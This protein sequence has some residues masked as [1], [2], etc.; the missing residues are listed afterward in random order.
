MNLKSRLF[1]KS[2]QNKDPEIRAQAVNESDDPE[3]KS[4]LTR[5][6]Q[7]DESALVRLAALNRI[8]T[9]HFW[10]DARLRETDDAIIAAADAFLAREVPRKA[11]PGLEAERLQWFAKTASSDLTRRMA[12]QAA[13]INLRRAALER[14]NSQGFLGDCFG[15]ETDEVLANEILERID[16]ESTL[17]RLAESLRKTSKKRAQAAADR[18]SLLRQASGKSG[19]D[20]RNANQLVQ[21]AEALARGQGDSDRKAALEELIRQWS[22]VVQPTEALERRFE[23]AVSIVRASLDRPARGVAPDQPEP[24]VATPAASLKLQEAATH[25]RN[26][27]RQARKEIKPGELL[28]DWDRAWNQLSQASEADL[29]LKEDMLPL[30]RELQV[31]A[32]QKAGKKPK[33]EQ[34]TPE[35]DPAK[36]ENIAAELDVRLDTIAQ[37]LE[38]GDIGKSHDLIRALRTDF[39]RL[40]ARARPRAVGGRL[41]RM[42]GRLKE[43][44]DWQHW[45]NN[46]HRDEL[47]EQ[48]EKLPGSGQHPDAVSVTLKEARDEWKRLEKLEVLPG[49][50]KRFAAPPGQWR[51]FQAACKQAFETA[52]PYFEKRQE[53][54][55]TNLEQLQKFI[56]TGMSLAT[57]DEPDSKLLQQTMRAARQAIRRMD[58]LPP[59]DRGKSAAGLRA[60]MDAIS[61]RLDEV[62]E[63]IE[64]TKRRLIAEA[65][66]LAQET[67]LKSAV[68]KAKALQAQWQKA[69]T[70][71]RKVEQKLWDEFREPIDPLFDRLKGER[72]EQKQADKEAIAELKALCLEAEKLVKVNDD[73]LESARG[74]MAGLAED[75]HAKPG[76]PPALNARF[77]KAGAEFE[78]RL[79]QHRN[80][81]RD[82]A[83]LKLEALI[84][85]VQ[86]LWEKRLQ[87]G[88]ADGLEDLL[89][90]DGPVPDDKLGSHLHATAA[91]LASPETSQEELINEVLKNT[92]EAR[93][94]AVEVE[95]LAGME[96]P[97][98]DRKLRMDYQVRRLALRMSERGA[99]PDL[100]TELASLQERW[101]MS[102]PHDPDQHSEL[103]RRFIKGHDM[104]RKMT[105]H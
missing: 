39:D 21:Q 36:T 33:P 63:Q 17:E 91:R 66:A 97:D 90:S 41:Q 27:V 95:F 38:D 72:Q 85:A 83:R 1:K 89:P 26:T 98:S 104:V 37:C 93:Q 94:I 84:K 96:T 81:A 9:E 10:L 54:Q 68:D 3:L 59:R 28:G 86:A 87:Q 82:E 19:P 58:D 15:T 76:R 103:A 16:Q 6:A 69:G 18:L 48:I 46:K 35:A 25:I 55:D 88:G 60:L 7:H 2:W 34:K 11:S 92:G 24:E 47:I 78:R 105:G 73:E 4:E 99:Q 13:D 64:L 57:A 100:R 71:R 74:R 22:M 44:R 52:K 101:T 20:Q 62:F 80:K 67:E 50:R 75:W 23:G 29:A 53:V 43:M 45:S 61:K 70:G 5:L 77:E 51:R 12:R 32:E 14:I 79:D 49:D 42:E 30:L 31:Q 102:L 56:D 40:P 65:R 8:N